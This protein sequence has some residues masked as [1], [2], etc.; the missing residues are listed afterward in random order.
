MPRP[1]GADH[2]SLFMFTWPFFSVTSGSPRA[3]RKAGRAEGVIRQG[4]GASWLTNAPPVVGSALYSRLTEHGSQRRLRA[5]NEHCKKV[6]FLP[7]LLLGTMVNFLKVT[8][9]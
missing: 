1:V 4:P 6:F 5:E 8:I 9:D 3:D 7:P 2:C